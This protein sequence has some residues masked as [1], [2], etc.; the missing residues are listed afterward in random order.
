MK[1]IILNYRFITIFAKPKFQDSMIIRIENT[2]FRLS[3]WLHLPQETQ[4][5]V[6]PVKQVDKII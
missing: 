2:D 4:G 3:A 6:V 1:K 5:V